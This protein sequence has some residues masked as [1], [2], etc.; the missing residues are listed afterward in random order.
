MNKFRSLITMIAVLISGVSASAVR[1]ENTAAKAPLY[2]QEFNAEST[3]SDRGRV[4]WWRYHASSMMHVTEY[5][6]NVETMEVTVVDTV[7]MRQ[8]WL[9]L[10]TNELAMVAQSPSHSGNDVK[11]LSPGSESYRDGLEAMASALLNMISLDAR[12]A[13]LASAVDYLRNLQ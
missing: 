5:F 8:Y 7:M 1:A 9:N 11:R 2:S 4:I 10:T 12:N 6:G 3:L 13:A